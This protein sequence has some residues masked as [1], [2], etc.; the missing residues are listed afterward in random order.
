LRHYAITNAFNENDFISREA[1]PFKLEVYQA[2]LAAWINGFSC[3]RSQ[4]EFLFTDKEEM[5]KA[6]TKYHAAGQGTKLWK[7]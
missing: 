2:G 6:I 7:F 3:H 4:I 1:N 5:C